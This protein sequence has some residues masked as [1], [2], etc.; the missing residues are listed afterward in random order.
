M[1]ARAKLQQAG[2]FNPKAVQN[3]NRRAIHKLAI[4]RKDWDSIK[5][6][7]GYHLPGSNKR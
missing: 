7:T 1:S 2:K 4:L 5:D 6:K 3:G